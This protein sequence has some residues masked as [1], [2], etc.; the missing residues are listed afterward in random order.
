MGLPILRQ[1]CSAFAKDG[2]IVF[3]EELLRAGSITF[4]SHALRHQVTDLLGR[5]R[6]LN[7]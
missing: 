2:R 7:A 3:Y 5:P 6:G 4:E 1:A